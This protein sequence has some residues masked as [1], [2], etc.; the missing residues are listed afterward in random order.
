MVQPD[1]VSDFNEVLRSM[2]LIGQPHWCFDSIFGLN[3]ALD[4]KI[5]NIVNDLKKS[6]H[7]TL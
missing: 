6:H 4:W 3:R 7:H 2:R 5:S 1:T